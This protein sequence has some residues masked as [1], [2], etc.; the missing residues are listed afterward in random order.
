M[1]WPFEL[2]KKLKNKWVITVL[3]AAIFAG[4]VYCM[5]RGL[6]DPFLYFRF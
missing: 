3:L 6:N 2:L 1:H 5:Y 4:S